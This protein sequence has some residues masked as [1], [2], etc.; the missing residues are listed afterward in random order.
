MVRKPYQTNPSTSTAQ[1]K[2]LEI[3]SSIVRKKAGACEQNGLS[4][5]AI[6]FDF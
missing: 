3:R 5:S 2:T 6:F 1:R 4:M